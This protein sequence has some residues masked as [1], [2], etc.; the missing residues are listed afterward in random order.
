M[1]RREFVGHAALALV[2]GTFAGTGASAIARDHNVEEAYGIIGQ[3]TVAPE[4]REFVIAAMLEGTRDMPGNI[5]Y[6]IAEDAEDDNALW[7]TEVWQT[8]T[9]HANSLKLPKVQEAIAKARPH[10]TGMGTRAETKP[11]VSSWD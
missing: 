7:I 1:Q 3:M 11:V 5:A 8:K 6:I 2:A 10:I 9:D 4:M